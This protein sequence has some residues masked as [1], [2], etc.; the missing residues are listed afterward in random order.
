MKILMLHFLLLVGGNVYADGC[1]KMSGSFY[2]QCTEVKDGQES[3]PRP[4]LIALG[5]WDCDKFNYNEI[6]SKQ[7]FTLNTPTVYKQSGAKKIRSAFYNGDDST[8]RLVHMFVTDDGSRIDTRVAS[9]TRT[10]D[11]TISHEL[12]MFTLENGNDPVSILKCPT[13]SSEVK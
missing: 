2:G 8:L 5:Q 1:I 4:V 12:K 3:T 6:N 7:Y 10:S 13:L 9:F 11:T